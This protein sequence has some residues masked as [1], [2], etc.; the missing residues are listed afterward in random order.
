LL[1]TI[2]APEVSAKQQQLCRVLG[3]LTCCI[4]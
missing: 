4:S 2:L 1:L 3:K